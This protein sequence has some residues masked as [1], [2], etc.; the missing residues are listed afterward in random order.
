MNKYSTSI[1]LFGITGDL[2]RKKILPAIYDLYK[3]GTLPESTNIV[4]FSRRDINKEELAKF[5]E[6]I[7][8]QE[9]FDK[10]FLDIVTYVQG[11]FDDLESY[12][13]LSNYLSELDEKNGG[14][15]NKLFYLSVPPTLYETIA[16]NIHFSGLSIPCGGEDGFSRI[17][18]E[19]PFGKDLKTAEELDAIL[20]RLFKEEQVYR[21]D[22]YLAKDSLYKIIGLQCANED[23]VRKWNNKFIDK[24]EIN[25]LEKNEVG[26]RGASYDGVGALRDVG[27]N[28]MLQM[29]SLIAMQVPEV[30]ISGPLQDARA[31]VLERL[32]PKNLGEIKST[33]RGQY[34]GYL[35]EA[36]VDPDSNTETFFSLTVFV[37]NKNFSG[38]PFVLTSG[39][40]LN[41]NLTEIVIHFKDGYKIVF[42]VPGSDS[43][44]AYQKILLD[45]ISGDQ[46]VFI[47]TREILAEW[48]F[49]TPIVE[50]WQKEKP[51]TYKKGSDFKDLI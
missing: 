49:I 9:N 10:N 47:S 39:K 3:K 22:H 18:I 12:K 34:E 33:K 24:V 36:G 42:D 16:N 23:I 4:G 40:A 32:I 21:I 38:V 6:E 31:E 26:S 1:V 43:L 37:N 7:L 45:C 20:G 2:A 14:C 28:H 25:L 27:Q 11:N 46:S 29:L 17:L 35:N 13:K 19:K 51:E 8:G 44:P 48:K 41:K 5:M 30:C 15:S 50:I